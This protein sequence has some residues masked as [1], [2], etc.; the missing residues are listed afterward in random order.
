MYKYKVTIEGREMG[1]WLFHTKHEI[2]LIIGSRG[3]PVGRG[4]FAS[5]PASPSAEVVGQIHSERQHRRRRDRR[6]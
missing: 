5:P 1:G 3:V 6:C 2:E 4:L